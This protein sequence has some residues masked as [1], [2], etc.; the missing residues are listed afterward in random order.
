MWALYGDNEF[1]AYVKS[2][3]KRLL[4]DML[5]TVILH[6]SS[7]FLL[8]S[9]VAMDS[10]VNANMDQMFKAGLVSGSD[11]CRRTVVCDEAGV[12]FVDVGLFLSN[13]AY[14]TSIL[15]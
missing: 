12:I 9:Q 7:T 11:G 4:R 5:K 3:L 1:L 14:R 10:E 2:D 6:R 15:Q 13:N 8:T